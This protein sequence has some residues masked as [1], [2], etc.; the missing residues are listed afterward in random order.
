MHRKEPPKYLP[1][2]E[3]FSYGISLCE[4][5]KI[6]EIESNSVIPLPVD[7]KN[8]VVKFAR[9]GNNLTSNL[10][11]LFERVWETFWHLRVTGQ[12]CSCFT[13]QT[14]EEND[15]YQRLRWEVK[16]P[17]TIY[18][19]RIEPASYFTLWDLISKYLCLVLFHN[20]SPLN[21]LDLYIYMLRSKWIL[22][23]IIT[24]VSIIKSWLAKIN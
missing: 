19:R 10:V 22:F 15:Q 8:R 1:V 4:V 17:L 18:M 23:G 11:G 12:R 5:F 6:C 21:L 13:S 2:P 7:K 9:A 24:K 3:A 16:W 14:N 20:G